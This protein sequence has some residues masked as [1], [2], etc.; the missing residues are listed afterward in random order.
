MTTTTRARSYIHAVAARCNGGWT[1]YS[2]GGPA[3]IDGGSGH[4]T[5]DD[6]RVA[7]NAALNAYGE[8]PDYSKTGYPPLPS[9]HWAKNVAVRWFDH[10]TDFRH[11]DQAF[12]YTPEVAGA[13]RLVTFAGYHDDTANVVYPHDGGLVEQLVDP[14][15]LSPCNVRP[16]W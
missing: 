16:T 13:G 11:A 10:A 1:A 9:D 12:L 2:I 3:T 5:P 4:A 6:A 14:V 7:F 15:N 8:R